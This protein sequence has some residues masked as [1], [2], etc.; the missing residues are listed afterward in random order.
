MDSV[1]PDL[2]VSVDKKENPNL[3]PGYCGDRGACGVDVK[4]SCVDEACAVGAEGK[5]TKVKNDK[6]KPGSADLEPGETRRLALRLTTKTRIQAGEAL[7]N[8]KT[9]RA[10]VTVRA[11]DAAGNVATAHR[12]I[13][14]VK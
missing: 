3:A 4:V 6:L 5:L 1:P 2:Q 10:K 7:D 11:K 12:T 13:T 9:V 14:L 8:G